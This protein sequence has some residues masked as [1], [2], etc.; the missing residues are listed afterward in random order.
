[1][2][3]EMIVYL[4]DR[5]GSEAGIDV[6]HNAKLSQRGDVIIVR[7][8]GWQWGELELT[9]PRYQV[10]K[11]PD[12][13]IADLQPLL[14][15]EMPQAGNELDEPGD[16]A[17]TLQYRGFHIVVGSM[18]GMQTADPPPTI[19]STLDEVTS[20]TVQK[21]PIPDPAKIGDSGRVIG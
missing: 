4:V 5:V 17:N 18:R 7:E 6:Y 21:P 15:W 10:I 11:V 19:D 8:D 13:T 9:D 2:M 3:A 16:T 14:S 20:L 12:A 1:M